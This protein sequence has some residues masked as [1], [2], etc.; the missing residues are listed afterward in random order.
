MEMVHGLRSGPRMSSKPIAAL[1]VLPLLLASP[2]PAHAEIHGEALLVASSIFMIPGGITTIGSGLQ[3]LL[4][5]EPRL[6]WPIAS[7]ITGALS[8]A[9]GGV[10]T[11]IVASDIDPNPAGVWA[12]AISPLAI[13][14]TT[15]L[16]GIGNFVKRGNALEREYEN[17]ARLTLAPIVLNGRSSTASGVAATIQFE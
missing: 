13:G 7:M 17:G 8:L 4:A 2:A 1:L 11:W 10:A 3:L 12:S 15:I 9:W 6:G 5:D 16:L 14:L